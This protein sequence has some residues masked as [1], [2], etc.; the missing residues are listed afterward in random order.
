M[1]VVVATSVGADGLS[2]D[3]THLAAGEGLWAV[4]EGQEVWR[5]DRSGWSR[6]CAWDGPPLRCLAQSGGDLFAGTAE[7]HLLQ[8]S[9]RSLEVVRSFEEAPARDTWY[10]PWGGPAD[11]R[12]AAVRE[13]GVLVNIHVG[14][15]LLSEEGGPWK[16]L[17]DIDVDVH[18]VIA[19]P[20]G[21]VLV[22]SGAG[23]FGM[24][25]DGGR[26]WSW[27]RA[28]LHGTYCRAVA[29]AG[30]HVLLSASGGPHGSRGAVYRRPLGSRKAWERT[31]GLFD[32]NIDTFW[33]SARGRGAAFVTEGGELWVSEDAGATWEAAPACRGQ[34]RAVVVL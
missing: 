34:P 24:S 8:L 13:G 14:G 25:E 10:T 30:D 23:G 32:G 11:T 2:G 33:L 18:Q 29:L 16:P 28:G 5:R 12:S 4:R 15:V 26:T 27:D 22:A 1:E 31:T 6:V 20:G 7:A 3:V 21:V 9:G 19:A 17:V